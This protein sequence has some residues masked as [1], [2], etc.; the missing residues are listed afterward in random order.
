M[1]VCS[2]VCAERLT[3]F[4]TYEC[5]QYQILLA[6]PEWYLATR[7]AYLL[8]SSNDE[9]AREPSLDNTLSSQQHST[10][11]ALEPASAL[12]TTVPDSFNKVLDKA[13]AAIHANQ[14]EGLATLVP[15]KAGPA[16]QLSALV[17][18]CHGKVARNGFAVQRLRTEASDS[19]AETEAVVQQVVGKA[20]YSCSSM[21]NHSCQPN[22]MVTYDSLPCCLMPLSLFHRRFEGHCLTLHTEATIARGDELCISY[23]PV[24]A[25]MAWQPARRDALNSQYGFDCTCDACLPSS[26]LAAGSRATAACASCKQPVWVASQAFALSMLQHVRP[27]ALVA[28]AR[29]SR[30]S[31]QGEAALDLPLLFQSWQEI[32]ELLE[33]VGSSG[34]GLERVAGLVEQLSTL[35]V[36]SE[37]HL[38]LGVRG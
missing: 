30:C 3:P 10:I 15:S 25:R 37:E 23:G 14:L 32:T 24:L 7:L 27:K 20:L 19:A 9:A 38:E 29:C 36:H 35:F 11:L 8:L 6:S 26:G 31:C 21:L 22:A 33:H 16:L 5:D 2:K 12:V 18:L 4:H 13:V 1:A 28:Q 17:C 34:K